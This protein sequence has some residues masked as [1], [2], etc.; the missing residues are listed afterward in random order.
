[1][2]STESE[3]L[4]IRP[5]RPIPF[6]LLSL[7][8]GA[9][10][11]LAIAELIALSGAVHYDAAA[12]QRF[13]AVEGSYIYALDMSGP[14]WHYLYWNVE[15]PPDAATLQ[16]MLDNDPTLTREAIDWSTLR[17]DPPESLPRW[18][19]LWRPEHWPPTALAGSFTRKIS[20]NEFGVGWPLTS[21]SMD[22]DDARSNPI[23]N[24]GMLIASGGPNIH[25][26]IWRP[27]ARGF[28]LDTLFW[29]AC[30][31]AATSAAQMWIKALRR[32]R[33]ACPTCGYDLR[34]LTPGTLCP[35]CGAGALPTAIK[36]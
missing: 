2:R 16:H 5:K 19:R 1:M 33:T 26:L 28:A 10:L 6:T 17:H 24:G 27:M 14:A 9:L 25:L 31:A 13:V 15:T 23:P 29:A 35:E 8:A 18:S 21:L 12:P 30:I 4:V 3:A 22:F 20:I 36:H 7:A 34:G 11:T 32:R